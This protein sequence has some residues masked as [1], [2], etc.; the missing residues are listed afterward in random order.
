MHLASYVGSLRLC[1]RAA[2]LLE[3]P[4]LLQHCWQQIESCDRRGNADFLDVFTFVETS[5]SVGSPVIAAACAQ[6]ATGVWTFLC[7]A[8]KP[9][10][11]ARACINA[12][13]HPLCG[14][15]RNVSSQCTCCSTDLARLAT[16]MPAVPVQCSS[17]WRRS[18]SAGPALL[19][20]V[21]PAR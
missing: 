12:G 13:V 6:T 17:T 16:A 2:A 15:R 3:A 1:S 21:R 4:A 10:K 5:L 9:G 18:T 7:Y 11:P 8:S 20:A 19:P 14:Y